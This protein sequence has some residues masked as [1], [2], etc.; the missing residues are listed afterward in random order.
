[1]IVEESKYIVKKKNI[2]NVINEDVNLNESE[3][4]DSV[5]SDED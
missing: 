1:M 5:K 2:K 3:D 4:D